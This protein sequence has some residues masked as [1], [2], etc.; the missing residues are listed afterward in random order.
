MVMGKY[1][2]AEMDLE[3]DPPEHEYSIV[4]SPPVLCGTVEV[5]NVGHFFIAIN[6]VTSS[7]PCM[8]PQQIRQLAQLAH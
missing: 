3:H 5:L 6:K 2:R 7:D 1:F 4:S 8:L